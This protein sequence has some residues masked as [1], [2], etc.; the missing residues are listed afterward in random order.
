M[1]LAIVVERLRNFILP[2]SIDIAVAA[3]K[4]QLFV[5]DEYSMTLKGALYTFRV[6]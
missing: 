2:K 6:G 3:L 4:D 5:R 1:E